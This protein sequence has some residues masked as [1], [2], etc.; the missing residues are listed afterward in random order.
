MASEPP[1]RCRP[2]RR[3]TDVMTE[4]RP[5]GDRADPEAFEQRRRALRRTKIAALV[6]LALLA[7]GAARTVVSRI[8]NARTLEAGVAQNA[9]PYVRTTLP[10]RSGSGEKL[11]LPGT[12]QGNVQ[13]PIAARANGYLKR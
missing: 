1:R 13:A 9:K 3:R 2:V 7:V 5:A 12:L 10:Q 11:A 4:P 6:V 8:S